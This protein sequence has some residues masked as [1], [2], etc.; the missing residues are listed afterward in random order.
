[1]PVGPIHTAQCK[2]GRECQSVPRHL[3]HTLQKPSAI[4]SIPSP[5]ISYVDL[6]PLRIH[7]Y[8]LCIVAGIIVAIFLTNARLTRRGAEKWV[9]ID[10]CLLAVP[11][12]IIVAL[13]YALIN[14]PGSETERE[15]GLFLGSLWWLKRAATTRP[16]AR[17]LINPAAQQEAPR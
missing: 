10:I 12:A 15:I 11:L 16:L 14:P 8:A 13:L 5:T 6:G 2:N 3:S 1:M 9:V 17:F 4:I 7:L